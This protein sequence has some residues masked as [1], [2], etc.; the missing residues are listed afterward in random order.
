MGI[1][2]EKLAG[3]SLPKV[4]N[5]INSLITSDENRTKFGR[6]TIDSKTKRGA[7]RALRDQK[8]GGAIA[9]KIIGT[10][11]KRMAKALNEGNA[12]LVSLYKKEES[13]LMNVAKTEGAKDKQWTKKKMSEIKN[14][15]G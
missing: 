4:K 13:R 3:V 1:Y 8:I 9:A 10:N 2:M 5:A 15:K 6:L 11:R 12:N 14:T 7:L